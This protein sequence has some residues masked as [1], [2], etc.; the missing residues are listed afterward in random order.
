VAKMIYKFDEDSFSDWLES[1]YDVSEYM[2]DDYDVD[3]YEK[4]YSKSRFFDYSKWKEY[5]DPEKYANGFLIHSL[6]K[7][8]MPVPQF[9]SKIS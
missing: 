4:A 1:N 8:G 3:P 7:E 6:R 9:K 2:S 5:N